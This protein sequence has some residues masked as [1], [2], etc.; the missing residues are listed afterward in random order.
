MNEQAER[1]NR[2][3]IPMYTSLFLLTPAKM[4]KLIN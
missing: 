2:K 3:I 1:L 4:D